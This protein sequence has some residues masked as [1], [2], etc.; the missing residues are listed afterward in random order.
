[1]GASR[2]WRL[3]TGRWSAEWW[4]LDPAP[5][6][7]RRQ[8]QNTDR[9]SEGYCRFSLVAYF[10]MKMSDVPLS[11]PTLVP[12]R[13]TRVCP[14]TGVFT[15]DSAVILCPLFHHTRCVFCIKGNVSLT[16]YQNINFPAL[17]FISS[18]IISTRPPPPNGLSRIPIKSAQDLSWRISAPRCTI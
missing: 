4:F 10:R 13:T 2:C 15:A 6:S 12:I 7:E 8:G 3:A 11:A 9:I 16:K 14:V 18:Y 5:L 17:R 1:M